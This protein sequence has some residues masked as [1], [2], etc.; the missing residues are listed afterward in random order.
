[1]KIR[2]LTYNI[3]KGFSIGNRR[4]ILDQIKR[5]IVA[6]HADLVH[7]QEVGGHHQG[8]QHFEVIADQTWPH[9]AYGKNAV[10]T[11]GHHGNAILSKFPIISSE[12]QDVSLN[13]YERRGLLHATINMGHTSPLHAFSLHLNLRESD[14]LEQIARLSKRLSSMVPDDAPVILAGDFNDWRKSV[15]PILMRDHQLNEAFVELTGK[16]ARTF[17]SFM[18]VLPLDRI[19]YRNLLCTSVS[20]LRDGGWKEISDHLPIIAEFETLH[21]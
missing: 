17:P 19:Y 8:A 21:D 3:H 20:T 2:I 12:N 15:T 18:P 9:F 4:F 16:H 11:R 14:R 10:H 13:Q 7:L 6:S 1:M 5:S